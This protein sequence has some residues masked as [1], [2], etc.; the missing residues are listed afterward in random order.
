ML[1]IQPVS[2]SKPQKTQQ[3]LF[4]HVSHELGKGG[5]PRI[6]AKSG[7]GPFGIN[8]NPSLFGH[9]LKSVLS[10]RRYHLLTRSSD[11]IQQSLP[12]A[13]TVVGVSKNWDHPVYLKP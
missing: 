3:A 10:D 2:A 13:R 8:R 9:A 11:P 5:F 4:M 7:V 12:G 1:E 6:T